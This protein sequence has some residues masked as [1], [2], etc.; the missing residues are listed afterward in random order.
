ME[1]LMTQW[2]IDTKVQEDSQISRN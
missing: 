1:K 2:I